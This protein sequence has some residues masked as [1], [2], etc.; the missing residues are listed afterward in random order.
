M[1]TY[2]GHEGQFLVERKYNG[3]F[4]KA[5]HGE[6]YKRGN[7][8]NCWGTLSKHIQDLFSTDIFVSG[9]LYFPEKEEPSEVLKLINKDKLAF[10]AHNVDLPNYTW[11]GKRIYLEQQGFKV[12]ETTP[13]TDNLIEQAEEQGIEGWVLKELPWGEMYKLKPVKTTDLVVIGVQ[14]GKGKYS[15][16]CGALICADVDGKE[17]CRCSGMTDEVR[18]SIDASWVGKI[19]EVAYGSIGSNGRL[20]FPRFIQVRDDKSIADRF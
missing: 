5:R 19:V 14:H 16:M 18:Q 3:V 17:M 2:N 15:G 9:E 7:E 1:R 11:T 8:K 13:F 10:V 20:I 4:L 6:A 12:P